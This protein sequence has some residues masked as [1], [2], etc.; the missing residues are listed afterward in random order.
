MSHSKGMTGSAPAAAT[1]Q[2][3]EVKDIRT[4]PRCTVGVKYKKITLRRR[5]LIY[6]LS[7]GARAT[8]KGITCWSQE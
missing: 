4:I 3:A 2:T 6:S 8:P 7:A 5:L 1:N